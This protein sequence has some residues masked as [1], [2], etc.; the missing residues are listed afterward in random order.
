MAFTTDSFVVKP[1]FF[2]GGDIGS[3][4]V[5]GTVNDLAMG[6]AA[7]VLERRAS[8]SKRAFR[9]KSSTGS[10]PPWRGQPRAAGEPSS[11]A[12][13]RWSKE[14]RATA[15]SST[16]PESESSRMASG[17][18]RIRRGRATGCILSGSIGDHGI[19]IMASARRAGVRNRDRE[20]FRAAARA[21]RGDAR[22]FER[23]SAA[24]AIPPAVGYPA[25]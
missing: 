5:H 7:A 10:R 9:P 12:T 20:R 6:G 19:A 3:L 1:L 8:F 4:A 17:C 11:P 18:R 21:G 16:P 13:P 2:P 25:H 24:C 15:S 14:A 23:R 22:R